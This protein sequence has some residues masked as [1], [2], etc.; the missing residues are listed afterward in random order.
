MGEAGGTWA[1]TYTYRAERLHRPASMAELQELVATAPRVRVLGSRHSFT[2]NAR[3][4]DDT[5]NNI[6][7]AGR[8][9]CCQIN[10]IY[11]RREFQSVVGAIEC[12]VARERRIISLNREL[13]DL[14]DRFRIPDVPVSVSNGVVIDGQVLCSNV[15]LEFY[16][17]RK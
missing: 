14:D 12:D 15:A 5:L 1:G 16:C 17:R 11:T 9:E 6:G 4:P 10:R 7:Q 2:A 8:V 3:L 13:V